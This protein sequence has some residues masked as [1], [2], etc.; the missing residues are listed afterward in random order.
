MGSTGDIKSRSFQPKPHDGNGFAIL[1]H[2]LNR[3]DFSCQETGMSILMGFTTGNLLGRGWMVD[4][5][6]C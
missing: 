1:K 2:A 3:T 6:I 5:N 4:E